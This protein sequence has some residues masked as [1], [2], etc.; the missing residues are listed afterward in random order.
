MKLG[1]MANPAFVARV[2][3]AREI[4]DA[5]EVLH[6]LDQT[7]GYCREKKTEDVCHG[8]GCDS[9]PSADGQVHACVGWSGM[10]CECGY[11]YALGQM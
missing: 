2:A 7:C 4:Q 8:E 5:W 1:P 10:C 3:K 9:D 6:S 11:G